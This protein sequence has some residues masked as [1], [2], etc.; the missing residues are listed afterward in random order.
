MLRLSLAL[1]SLTDVPIRIRNIRGKRG[2]HGKDGGMKQAHLGGAAWLMHACEADTE[3][4]VL[5][6]R[7]LL[8]QPGLAAKSSL[9]EVHKIVTRDGVTVGRAPRGHNTV[10]KGMIRHY[11]R[12][13]VD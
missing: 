11:R 3:G 1:S 13:G 9:K 2:A 12:L 10:S 8:F 7:E 5:R 6:S 4:M